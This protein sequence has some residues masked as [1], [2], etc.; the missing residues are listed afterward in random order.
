MNSRSKLLLVAHTFSEATGRSLARMGTLIHNQGALFKYLE[1]GGSC[2]IDTYDK[3]MCWLSDH[4]PEATPWPEGV[5]R[6]ECLAPL[7]NDEDDLMSAPDE[8]P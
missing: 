5:E 8:G 7:K 1:G 3:A 4:W 2:T 6:P